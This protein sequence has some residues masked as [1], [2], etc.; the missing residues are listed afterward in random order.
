MGSNFGL[1]WSEK[2]LN[3]GGKVVRLGF[4]LFNSGKI[5]IEENEK[6]CF[7]FSVELRINL[8][9]FSHDLKWLNKELII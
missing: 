8:K 9:M 4:F 7:T 1:F 3:F 5:Y 6:P 2:Y